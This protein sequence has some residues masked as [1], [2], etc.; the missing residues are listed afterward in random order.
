VHANTKSVVTWVDDDGV[1]HFGN[2]QF[3]P[4]SG[5][6][7]VRLQPANI[8]Q[9]PQGAESIS[10]RKGGTRVVTVS[11][12]ARKNKRGFRGYGARPKGRSRSG[13]R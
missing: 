3:A 5:A 10:V 4:S 7:E 8:M 11:K 1:T 2:P 12:T 13:R 6:D 9:V